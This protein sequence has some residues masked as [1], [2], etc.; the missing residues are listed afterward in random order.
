[1]QT[2][3]VLGR[4]VNFA[5]LVRAADEYATSE[6]PVLI[7]G[8]T[9][10]GKEFIARRLHEKSKRRS[11]P[12]LPVNCG[13]IPGGLFES[14]LFGH[15]KGAFSGAVTSSR[16]LIRQAHRGTLFLD[17]IGE[18]TP[19]LQVKCLR[20]LDAGEVRSVGSARVEKFDVRI[21]AATNRNLYRDVADG[22]FRLD[23]LER[24]SVLTLHVPPLRERGTDLEILAR[25]FLNSWNC[26]HDE[27]I[28]SK[29]NRYDWPGNIRQL[30]N[31]LAR[32]SVLGRPRIT[33]TLVERLVT[34]EKALTSILARSQH[35]ERASLADIEKQAILERLEQ[36]RGNRKKTAKELGISKSSLHEKL[37]RWREQGITLG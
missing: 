2:E 23:L 19:D 32:A 6:W 14:E 7:L 1:M 37:R 24:L 25:H 9:G 17:E 3:F 11:G 5:R 26:V 21:V 13:A 18:I 28:F 20:L 8:E 31:L 27:D 29:L 36:L 35:H 15:E 30:R 10:V 33:G 16:G 34:D 22:L 4:S 12:F